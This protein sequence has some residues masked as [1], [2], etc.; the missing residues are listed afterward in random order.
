[1]VLMSGSINRDQGQMLN[2][3]AITKAPMIE[4]DGL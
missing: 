4:H 3:F 2:I 1:M